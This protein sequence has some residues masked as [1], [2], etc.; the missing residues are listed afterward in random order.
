MT[1]KLKIAENRLRFIKTVLDKPSILINKKKVDV[2]KWLKK[3]EYEEFESY[4]YLLKMPMYSLTIE[5][6]NDIEKDYQNLKKEFD[7]L[8]KKTPKK[9]WLD[10]LSQ[11]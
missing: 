9:L 2:E 10:D 1:D 3:E 4:D 8:D 5:K 7:I 11:F 6:F